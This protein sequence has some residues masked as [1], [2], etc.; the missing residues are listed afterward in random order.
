[1]DLQFG[2][3]EPVPCFAERVMR[4]YYLDFEL[5]RDEDGAVRVGLSK[6]CR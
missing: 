1:M 2:S 3:L 4:G 5:K 6:R